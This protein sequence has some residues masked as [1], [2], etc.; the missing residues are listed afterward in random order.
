M[1]LNQKVLYDH[2]I[3]LSKENNGIIGR[4]A[5]KYAQDLLKDYPDFAAKEKK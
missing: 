1:K 5:A 3:K 2:F 4:N